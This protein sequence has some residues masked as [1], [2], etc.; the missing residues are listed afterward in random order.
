MPTIDLGQFVLELR[1]WFFFALIIKICTKIAQ[2]MFEVCKTPFFL[3]T[4]WLALTYFPDTIAWI[5]IK[6]GEIQI[7]IFSLM[8]SVIMPEIFKTASGDYASWSDIWQAGM[9]SLPSDFVQILNGVGVA[10]IIGIT[11]ST[12]MSGWIISLYR[13][14]MLRAG[15]L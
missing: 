5:F 12:L 4:I 2:T 10:E 3:F 6:I 15:L 11:T 1:K 9:N 13:K 8:L 14:T 7:M